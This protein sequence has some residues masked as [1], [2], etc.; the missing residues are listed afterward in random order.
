MEK[1]GDRMR[2]GHPAQKSATHRR[3]YT[4]N[5]GSFPDHLRG[6]GEKNNVGLFIRQV[7]FRQGG[8]RSIYPEDGIFHPPQFP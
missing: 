3:H 5:I 4:F 6:L 2:R 7:D 1:K 8:I